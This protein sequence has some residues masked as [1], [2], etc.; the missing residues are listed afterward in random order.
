MLS[1]PEWHFHYF[2]I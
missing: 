2:S 1:F